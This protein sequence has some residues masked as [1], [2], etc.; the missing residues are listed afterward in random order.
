VLWNVQLR[1]SFTLEHSEAKL[2]KIAI[3]LHF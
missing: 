3:N 1:F 2:A